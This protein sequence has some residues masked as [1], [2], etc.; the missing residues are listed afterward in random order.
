MERPQEPLRARRPSTPVDA[1]EAVTPGP[2]TWR[3]LSHLGA[4]GFYVLPILGDLI[5]IFVIWITKGREDP[6]VERHARAS[7]NFQLSI[8]IMKLVTIPL[9]LILIGFPALAVL[10]L[11][12]LA[13]PLVAAIRAGNGKFFEYPLAFELIGPPVQDGREAGADE[14]DARPAMGA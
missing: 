7:L 3:V 12:D 11:I 1:A 2:T 10:I 8:W 9:C 5:P 4:Y 14:G 13:L 6:E